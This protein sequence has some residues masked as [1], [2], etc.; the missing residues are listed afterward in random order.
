M[1]FQ[2][3]PGVNTS[4]IDLTTSVPVLS[5]SDGALAGV[6]RWGPLEER[7]TID[8]ESA[9]VN[10]FGKPT[11]FNAETWFTA[12]SF[13]AHGGA[14]NIVRVANVTTTNT[15]IGAYTAIAIADGGSITN[16]TLHNV[17]NDTDYDDKL[18][19]FDTDAMYI[20]RFPGELGNSL[21][22][23]VCDT[24][25]SFS[26]TIT[27]HSNNE[28]AS[29]SSFNLTVGSNTATVLVGFSANGD[30]TDA[31]TS[32]LATKAEL[33]VGDIIVGGNS[34]IG[35]QYLKITSLGAVTTNSTIATFTIGLEDKY[36]LHTAYS[37]N[38][39]E[40]KWGYFNSVTAAPGT[41][42]YVTA[43][44][45]TSAV[46]EVHVVISDEN[47]AF[48]G[49]PGTILEVYEGLSRA[50]DAK[51][52]DGS[53][54]YYKTV[55]NERSQYVRWGY[56]R[57]T[58]V[59]ATAANIATATSTKPAYISF[60]GGTDGYGESDTSVAVLAGGY[61]MFASAEDVDVAF[62]LAG[63]SRATDGTYGETLPNYITDNICEIRKDCVAFISPT[64]E[65]VV[66]NAGDQ[67]TDIVNFRNA[68]RSTSY[69]I[70]DSGY[71]YMY[72]KYN[73]LYRW[74]PLN[75]DI[76][77]LCAKVDTT[78]DPWWS[79]AGFNRGRIK[80]VVK[81]AYNP[82]K[83]DRD[84]LYKNGVNPVVTFPGEGTLLFGDKTLL[85][86]PSAFDR[87]NVRRLFIVLEK[88]IST[89]AKY[90]MFDFNDAFTRAQ[91]RN[92]IIPYLRDIQGRRGITDFRVVCDESN[93][94][95]EVIDRGEFIG[96]IYIK[97]ARSINF[98]QLNFV[99]VRTG[100]AFSEVVGTF[101]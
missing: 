57:S 11:N 10:R 14:L 54:L 85:T 84:T 36:R 18:A 90:T 32:A 12:A 42:E 40:Q 28:I 23:S 101:G 73:D 13:L 52:E 21:K 61:D 87:I 58:A 68:L 48:T 75:G 31:N 63:K 26:K 80:N 3:S 7:V 39:I 94:T 69:A 91:F 20:A 19:T 41:S 92:M 86:K 33:A 88:S 60:T 44:G 96:D 6:F 45:N 4:E 1:P 98:I 100:V 72:D 17:K 74:I 53:S 64:K 46:D 8:S 24:V 81:L 99:A 82:S 76:A 77:G 50:T 51:T 49:V 71:K 27:L 43:F 83:A 35:T 30:I 56:D 55:I 79:P 59:S 22:I 34:T 97:P 9:L 47:G 5:V 66:N 37:A 95:A 38:T 89:A 2:I 16:A 15:T 93:N 25:N 78:N 70:L 29:N 62:I 67:A 65:D